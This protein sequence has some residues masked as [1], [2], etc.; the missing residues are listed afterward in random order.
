MKKKYRV[1]QLCPQKGCTE[2]HPVMEVECE[3]NEC[4]ACLS[5]GKPPDTAHDG[6]SFL[7]A[8]APVDAPEG[9][10]PEVREMTVMTVPAGLSAA[11]RYGFMAFLSKPER[12][13]S[14]EKADGN[15]ILRHGGDDAP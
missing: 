2:D 7:M 9:T 3:D 6:Y 5:V 8:F 14:C 12:G 4:P 15:T 13:L 10:K 11:P 1:W